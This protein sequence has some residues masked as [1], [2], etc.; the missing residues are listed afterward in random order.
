MGSFSSIL[1]HIGGPREKQRARDLFAR[2]QVVPDCCSSAMLSLQVRHPG[3]SHAAAPGRVALGSPGPIPPYSSSRPVSSFAPASSWVRATSCA[4][5]PL[6][7]TPASCVL[8]QNKA[9]P[10]PVLRACRAPYRL[11]HI[12]SCELIRTARRGSLCCHRPRNAGLDGDP[13]SAVVGTPQRQ[14]ARHG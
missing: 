6:P 11:L 10:P 3:Q 12:S 13:Q 4:Y 8:Q 5:P 1:D 2:M 9:G 7:P 14:P